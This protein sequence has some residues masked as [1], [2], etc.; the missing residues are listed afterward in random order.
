M[1][2]GLNGE[3]DMK[4]RVVPF[5]E[6]SNEVTRWYVVQYKGW[7]SW[8]TVTKAYL[9]ENKNWC[10]PKHPMLMEFEEAVKFA[11]GLTKERLAEHLR[12]ETEKYKAYMKQLSSTIVKNN[13]KRWYGET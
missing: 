6:T 1:L 12:C 13:S 9:S 2:I 10:D 11:E 8:H 7:F 4:V 3:V 5:A